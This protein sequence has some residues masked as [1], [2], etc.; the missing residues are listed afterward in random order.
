[1]ID[2]A[3]LAALVP[4]VPRHVELRAC[5]LGGGRVTVSALADEPIALVDGGGLRGGRRPGVVPA[6]Q[7]SAVTNPNLLAPVAA[8]YRD[9]L[10]REVQSGQGDQMRF[11]LLVHQADASIPGADAWKSLSETDGK[12]IDTDYAKI[13]KAPW[14]PMDLAEAA[15]TVRGDCY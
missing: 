15:A 9:V 1:V 12:S 13:T 3:S 7:R 8:N 4:D 6:G 11:A 5:L 14:L 2:P 10:E